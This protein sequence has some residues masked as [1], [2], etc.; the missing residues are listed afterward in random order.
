MEG[1]RQL[2]GGAA[3]FTQAWDRACHELATEEAQWVTSLRADGFKA[4][5]P[6]DAHVDRAHRVI[7]WNAPV[8]DDGAAAGDR[9]ML[10]AW[11]PGA[12]RQEVRLLVSLDPPGQHGRRWIFEDLPTRGR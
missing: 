1:L 11:G 5:H 9:V 8:F 7:T 10:G 4:A 2:I 3:H 12:I 6:I